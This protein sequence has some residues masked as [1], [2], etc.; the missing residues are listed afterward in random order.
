[1]AEIGMRAPWWISCVIGCGVG[2]GGGTDTVPH[3]P[4]D[5]VEEVSQPLSDLSAQCVFTPATHVLALTLEPGDI[6]VIARASDQTITIND[7]ACGAATA[8]SV[9]R[10]DV[11]EGTAGAQTVIF[12]Y[13]GGLF[14]T[15]VTGAAGATID[16]GGQAGDSVKLIG[17]SGADAFAAG[18]AGVAI[19]ADGF[20]D[21]TLAGAPALVVSLDDGD[22][23]FSGAGT[24]ATG[25]ALATAVT[26]YGGAGNDTLRGGNGDDLLH[27]GAGNDT[28]TTGALPD[29]ADA[30]HGDGGT[31]TADYGARTGAIG[32]TIDDVA[33]DGAPGE[34][35]DV[36]TDIEIL[37]G[38][39]G[40]D[41]LTGSAGND[42]IFGGP[43]NDTIAGGAGDDTL[44]GDAGND[45]FDEGAQPSGA[46][47]LNGG[48]GIDTVS[49]A[50]RTGNVTV[51]LDALAN[52]GEALER[53]KVM[54]DVENVT[55]GAGDDTLTGSAADNVLDGGAG[56]DTISGGAGD[57][58]LRGGAGDDVLH[59]DAGNDRFDE[60][61]DTGDDTLVGGP[62]FDTADYHARTA[63]LVVVMDGATASG[64]LGETD[65][66]ATDI[67]GL[68]GGSGADDLTGNAADNQLEGGPGGA[69]DTLRGLAGD[70]VLD[71][72][73]GADVLDCGTGDADIN[74]DATTTGAASCEL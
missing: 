22:D 43:G 1:M 34:G 59:G 16:L 28:F 18:A 69:V 72:G 58:T 14:A 41:Q 51:I 5:G 64:E 35:D 12:D 27:G 48:A 47:V 49:Y 68:I 50:A 70:D 44:Y 62:G 15:G 13:G 21:V 56:D 40:D 39:A 24:A 54:L 42:T 11:R 17:T 31:D 74:L 55:G 3:R 52:D 4:I 26:V 37:K 25:A 67:E 19:N 23:T 57:D 61:L 32:V 63:D 6:A 60:A 7:I 66:L 20:V 65:H 33:D 9:R 71:G 46:D 45:T 2:C 36:A 53:D 29:G 8:S 73:G 30:L 38:G 10:I